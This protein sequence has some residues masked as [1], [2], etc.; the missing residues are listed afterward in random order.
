[1]E[2]R[3]VRNRNKFEN[4]IDQKIFNQFLFYSSVVD[5]QCYVHFW[6]MAK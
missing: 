5:L 4:Q 2:N 3:L 1:M 6:C